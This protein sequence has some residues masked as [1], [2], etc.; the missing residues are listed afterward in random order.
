MINLS[1]SY[2][3]LINEPVDGDTAA[4]DDDGV[5]ED[6]VDLVREEQDKRS[7]TRYTVWNRIN[8]L[9]QDKHSETG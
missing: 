1:A 4:F 2:I 3:Y 7:E 5:G 9:K 6:T 8:A